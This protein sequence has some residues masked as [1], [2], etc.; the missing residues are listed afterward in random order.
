[1]KAYP[2]QLFV[3]WEDGGNEPDYLIATTDV[4]NHA[5]LGEKFK[6]GV[7]QLVETQDVKGVAVLS[8][9]KPAR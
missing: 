2:K 4:I 3:K 9:K 6:V 7:Y 1:M 5:V 8:D